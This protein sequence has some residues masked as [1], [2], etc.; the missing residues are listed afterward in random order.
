MPVLVTEGHG[1]PLNIRVEPSG[2]GARVV[3]HTSRLPAYPM[4][5]LIFLTH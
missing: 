5:S 2:A 3:G 4:N 1:E